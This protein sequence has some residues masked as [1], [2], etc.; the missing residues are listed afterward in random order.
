MVAALKMI[1]D[2]LSVIPVVISAVKSIY[3]M[4]KQMQYDSNKKEFQEGTVKK[5]QGKV[6]DSFDSGESG[7]PSGHGTIVGPND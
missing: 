3:D 5:D 7:K 6:E 4:W 2:I 1:W